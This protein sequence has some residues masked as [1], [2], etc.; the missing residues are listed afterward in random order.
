M[1]CP[2]Y[3]GDAKVVD[4]YRDRSA[5]LSV[6]DQ[7]RRHKV[8][9]VQAVRNVS[10]WNR[11]EPRERALANE[12]VLGV[13]RHR[14]FLDRA[15]AGVTRE[16]P[17]KDP[18][19]MDILRLGAY[20]ILRLDGIPDHAAVDS[21]V[22]LVRRIKGPKIAGFV[23]GALRSLAG[24]QEEILADLEE[25]SPEDRYSI[26]E[27]LL[28]ELRAAVGE[29]WEQELELLNKPSPITYRSVQG[30]V[31][32]PVVIK[33]LARWNLTATGDPR[34]PEAVILP[35][36]QPAYETAPFEQ[37][38]IMPQDPASQAVIALAD[39]LRGEVVVDLGA[40]LGT[41]TEQLF[42]R[43][44]SDEQRILAVDISP[45]RLGKLKERLPDPA[46]GALVADATGNLPLRKGIAGTVILDAPCSNLGTLR[47]HP[48]VKWW[49][50]PKDLRA[51][52]KRQSAMLR[53]AARLLRPG[54][55]LVY[56]VCSFARAEGVDLVDA[57]LESHPR[58]HAVPVPDA[59]ALP[60]TPF[61]LTT[62][63][64][65][66][67]DMFFAAIIECS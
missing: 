63:A 35:S 8:L 17:R 28:G 43:R 26:P 23:N 30:A 54:G 15:L 32:V 5:V 39:P 7:V 33:E 50:R 2:E 44:T 29:S 56:A 40:G 58:Y 66:G 14:L 9:A 37:G 46:V 34:F 48:E 1:V 12:I 41:K 64:R 51:H 24:T 65:H 22:G 36:G 53:Q 16:L 11:L 10:V 20:Q 45:S 3:S 42:H 19:L 55:R 67:T 49:R 62:P 25:W 31:A 60:G 13:L 52:A 38:R 59:L 18:R 27:W 21:T 6:L 47:R 61:M 57:F 4:Q